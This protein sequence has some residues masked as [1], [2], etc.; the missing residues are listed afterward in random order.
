MPLFQPM[1]PSVSQRRR[2]KI[3]Y[4]LGL[5]MGTVR[6]ETVRPWVWEANRGKPVRENATFSLGSDGNLILAEANGQ[7]VWQTNTANK[8]VVSFTIL[9]NGNMVLSDSTG[10]FVWQSFD[11]SADTLLVGQALRVSGGPY[12]LV[13]R[14]SVTNNIDGVYSLVIEPKRLA[15]YY[16]NSMCYWSSTFPELNRKKCDYRRCNVGNSG[17]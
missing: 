6:S 12:K 7:I 8:G 5:C 4:T 15:L 3:W 13:S 2:F 9:S 11:S 1:K 10:K 14:D 16:K 17:N